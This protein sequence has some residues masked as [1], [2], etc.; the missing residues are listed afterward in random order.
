MEVLILLSS[1]QI[2]FDRSL[3][4]ILKYVDLG[5]HS[6]Y[7]M[8]L[9]EISMELPTYVSYKWL[10]IIIFIKLYEFLYRMG[11]N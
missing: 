6:T 3:V 9:S 1:E 4:R 5:T 7:K 11:G 10:I 8:Y 2:F